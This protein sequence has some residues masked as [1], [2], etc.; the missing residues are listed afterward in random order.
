MTAKA[1]GSIHIIHL[2]IIHSKLVSIH[3]RGER[4]RKSVQT[5]RMVNARAKMDSLK[6]APAMLTVV[7]W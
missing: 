2:A 5:S 6:T 1:S 3:N 7:V 4:L